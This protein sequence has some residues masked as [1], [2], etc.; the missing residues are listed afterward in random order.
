[1]IIEQMPAQPSQQPQ[2]PSSPSGP[3][4]APAPAPAAPPGNTMVP[5]GGVQQQP[6]GAPQP[7]APKQ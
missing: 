4:P 3:A 7:Y 5:F 1:M 2:R 6:G